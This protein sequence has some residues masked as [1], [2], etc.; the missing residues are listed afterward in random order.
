MRRI[1]TLAL[2]AAPLSALADGAPKH[3]LRYKFKPGEVLRWEVDQRS[4]VRNTMEGASEEAQTKTVSLK[5]WKVVDVMPD[6]EIEFITLVERVRMQNKLPDRAEMVFDSTDTGE[7]PPGF[8][9]AARAIGVPLSSVRMTPWGEIVSRDVKHHQPAADPHEQIVVALPEGPVAVG[10]SWNQPVEIQV[11]A[12]DG[13]KKIAARR[14]HTLEKVSAGVATIATEFQVLSPTTPEIDGQLA[15]RLVR[16]EI[17]FDVDNGRVL[18]QRL[19]VDRRVLGFA[20]PAS[21]MHLVTRLEEQLQEG[22][23]EVASRK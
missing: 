22:P 7:A 19:D 23:T 8:E 3:T 9:D 12:G 4:S 14:K 11:N 13:V 6:G 15:H 10:D 16:G 1:L 21:S 18:S 2:L 17:R 5:A 20:G